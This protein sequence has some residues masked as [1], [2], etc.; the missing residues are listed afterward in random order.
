MIKLR[1]EDESIAVLGYSMREEDI[2][3]NLERILL[4]ASGQ[5]LLRCNR[6]FL[7]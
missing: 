1:M 5:G 4:L 2:R 3:W 7:T 6:K